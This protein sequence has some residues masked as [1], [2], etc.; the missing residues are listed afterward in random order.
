MDK[1]YKDLFKVGW[2]SIFLVLPFTV[3]FIDLFINTVKSYLTVDLNS[4][5]IDTTLEDLFILPLL[6]LGLLA[7][8]ISSLIFIIN[9]RK[10]NIKWLNISLVLRI[11]AW[12]VLTVSLLLIMGLAIYSLAFLR[13]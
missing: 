6:V 1:I 7:G 2:A 9:N 8:S 3:F 5:I 13:R 12:G 11:I 4:N 10:K